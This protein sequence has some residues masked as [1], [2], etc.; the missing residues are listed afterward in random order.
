[1]IQGLWDRSSRYR[2]LY[3]FLPDRAPRALAEHKAICAACIAGNA[4]KAGSAVRKNVRQTV[5]G[6]AV[7][8]KGR[9]ENGKAG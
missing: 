1:M 9:L 8:L 7:E 3:T 2:H 5:Q 4:E 6:L